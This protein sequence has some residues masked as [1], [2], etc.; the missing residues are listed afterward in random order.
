MPY[1]SFILVDEVLRRHYYQ[2]LDNRW[3]RSLQDLKNNNNP[4][5]GELLRGQATAYHNYNITIIEM[6]WKENHGLC[7]SFAIRVAHE[8]GIEKVTNYRNGG[9]HWVAWVRLF[10]T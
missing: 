1:T 8:T 2:D 9:T 10:R 3:V 4:T 6:L 7:T 5:R